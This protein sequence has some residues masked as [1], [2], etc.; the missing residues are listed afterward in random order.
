M[1]HGVSESILAGY[2]GQES[3]QQKQ[4]EL[5]FTIIYLIKMYSVYFLINN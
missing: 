2:N 3:K 1:G 5:S 4:M